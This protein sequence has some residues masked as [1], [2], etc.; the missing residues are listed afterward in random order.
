[1]N[2]LNDRKISRQMDGYILIHFY[3]ILILN[4]VFKINILF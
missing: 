1:M 2:E 3:A 4:I